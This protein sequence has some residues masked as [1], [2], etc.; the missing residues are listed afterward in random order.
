MMGI[1]VQTLRARWVSFAG[2]AVALVL[3]VAQVTAMGLLLGA[4]LDLPD[5]PPQRFATAPAVVFGTDPEWNPAHHDLGVRSLA[6]AKGVPDDVVRRLAETGE[7]VLDRAFYAQVQGGRA[8]QVG[9]PWSVAR[10][11]GYEL[12]EGRAPTSDTEIVVGGGGAGVA[13]G[14][15]AVVLTAEAARPYQVVG[16][17]APV[18]YEHAVFFTDSEAARISPRVES[19]V[20]M[21]PLDAVRSAVSSST[22]EVLVGGDRHRVD[23]SEDRDREALDNTV[24]LLPITASVAGSTAIFVV[25]STFAFAVVQRRREVALLRTV[26][27]TP[28]Q[29]RRM[30]LAE[31]VLVGAVASAA[32]CA[33]G[34]LGARLLARWLISLGLSP[35][36]FGVSPSLAPAVLLPIAGA[37]LTGVL[38]A[39]C[40]AAAASWRAGRVR[41]IEA[42]RDATVDR[43]MTSGR[44]LLGVGGLAAGVGMV[45]YVAFAAPEMTLVPNKYVPT[46]LVPIGAFALLAPVLVGPLTRLLMAPFGGAKGAG[47]MVV[48]ESALTARRRTAAT[49]VPVL[50]TVGLAIS[51]LGATDTINEARDSGLRN[52]VTAD[53]VLTPD[54][55]PGIGRAAVERVDAV[56]GVA[57]V[58]PVLTTLYTMDGDR[59]QENDGYAV[60]P[61]A[62]SSTL[63]LPVVEGSLADLNDDSIVVAKSW[64]Y[65]L[66]QPVEVFMADGTTVSLRVAAIYEALRGQDIGYLTQ[67]YAGTG[68]YARNGLARRAYV[69]LEPGTDPEAA[70]AAMRTAVSGLGAQVLTTERLVATEA[71]AARQLTNVRQRSVAVIVVV[72]CFIAIVNT[73][74]MAT[75]DR[76]R[77]L[78]VLRLA[79]TTP[80]QVVALFAAESLL[81]AGIGVVLAL[82]ASAL[83]LAGLW[84]ALSGLFGATPVVVPVGIVAAI[85]AVAALLAVLGA[86]LPT[87]ASLRAS[88]VALTTARE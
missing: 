10:F 77:D 50:L 25:A 88:A 32:G 70:A 73:L 69:S 63:D 19:V 43:P 51:L 58:A 31:A 49:A 47:A 35:S 17:T 37:F 21:G 74:L 83:N 87:S 40:G 34:L 65:E 44:W 3:G 45:G 18:D 53:F 13:V 66:G 71:A 36:W 52:Q 23:V 27:A 2:T 6:E 56:P 5:R 46:L 16:V 39:L 57:V 75:A 15:Q 68:A 54:G 62:L 14:Q 64:G 7:V 82:M 9:H 59:I 24:T 79:G 72:F 67:K 29:V 22:V 81:V 33:L 12:A 85:A 30:V 38:V 55:S 41:P 4:L 76:R 1:A 86:V 84:V 11:G 61:A 28:K 20:A 8:D 48:R 60:E 80:R 78:A 26:G 42:L